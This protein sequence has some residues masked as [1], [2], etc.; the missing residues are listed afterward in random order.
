MKDKYNDIYESMTEANI[1][2]KDLEKKALKKVKKNIFRVA[3]E[4]NLEKHVDDITRSL[5]NP[6][7]GEWEYSRLFAKVH[8]YFL[9][10][11]VQIFSD[12]LAQ[13]KKDEK[14]YGKGNK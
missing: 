6:T 3:N 10:E 2:L 9:E 7:D 14:K 12:E 13:I 1:N 8:Q 4:T 5:I 11:F